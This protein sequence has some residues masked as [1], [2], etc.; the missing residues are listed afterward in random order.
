MERS[1]DRDNGKANPASAT[2]REDI[3]ENQ[4]HQGETEYSSKETGDGREGFTGGENL[5]NREDFAGRPNATEQRQDL[6]INPNEPASE[7][8]DRGMGERQQGG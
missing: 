4:E 2:D 3:R 8:I 1:A 7:S 6:A 5:S